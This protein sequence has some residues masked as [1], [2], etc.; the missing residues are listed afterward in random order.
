MKAN[1]EFNLFGKGKGNKLIKVKNK[2][3]LAKLLNNEKGKRCDVNHY[4]VSGITDMSGLFSYVSIQDDKTF[5][6]S[7]WDVS[8]V[9]SMLAMFE[10]YYVDCDISGWNVSNVTDMAGLFR[11][12]GCTSD[13]S[14]W[15]VSNVLFMDEMF[16]KAEFNIGSISNWDVSKV[17]SM[18]GM[19]YKSQGRTSLAKWKPES[20]KDASHM[21]SMSDMK[22][23]IDQWNLTKTKMDKD[24]FTG[25]PMPI[26]T[27]FTKKQNSIGNRIKNKLFSSENRAVSTSYANSPLIP[28]KGTPQYNQIVAVL[29]NMGVSNEMIYR[30]ETDIEAKKE[31]IGALVYKYGDHFKNFI[32]VILQHGN[33]EEIKALY[34]KLSELQEAGGDWVPTNQE[35]RQIQ[36]KL[37]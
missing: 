17:K 35:L 25:S 21:F 5:D 9:T 32:P 29:N 15:N 26:P 13:L 36:N 31:V 14:K 33:T 4:D 30:Y 7:K 34:L 28:P 19:F 10:G 12:A 6:F 1:S 16:F 3:H 23:K 8:N 2:K 37:K 11:Y 18:T 20:L 27:W 22:T 24:M